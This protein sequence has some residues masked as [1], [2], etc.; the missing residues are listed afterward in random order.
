[1][2]YKLL[3]DIL[4]HLATSPEARERFNQNKY[5]ICEFN[6]YLLF[7]IWN[8][9]FEVPNKQVFEHFTPKLKQIIIQT[10]LSNTPDGQ[11]IC[12]FLDWKLQ[13]PTPFLYNLGTRLDDLIK[14][15]TIP[16]QFID[17]IKDLILSLIKTN[18]EILYNNPHRLN[19]LLYQTFTTALFHGK[20]F[21]T[22]LNETNEVYLEEI[23]D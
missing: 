21:E 1:M 23:K 17:I 15:N 7:D 11:A 4:N 13:K 2:K 22:A 9:T 14:S 6:E 19:H 5:F 16:K 18:K 20:D 3:T 10:A 8:H 12:G